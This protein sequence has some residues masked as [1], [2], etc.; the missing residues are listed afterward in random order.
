MNLYKRMLSFQGHVLL[1]ILLVEIEMHEMD[2]NREMCQQGESCF[3]FN[4]IK[5]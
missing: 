2:K 1:K 4:G 3:K 5:S